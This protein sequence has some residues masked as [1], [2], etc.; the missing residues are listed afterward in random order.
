VGFA[1]FV[2]G[3]LRLDHPHVR[4]QSDYIADDAGRVVVDAVGRYE[5]MTEDAMALLRAVGISH[6][7]QHRNPPLRD[8][9][10]IVWP[11]ELRARAIER[12]RDDF[13]ILGYDP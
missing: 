6:P 12:Y 4:P 1:R 9:R 3:V 10:G 11:E 8:R 7:L 5:R 13:R 2:E